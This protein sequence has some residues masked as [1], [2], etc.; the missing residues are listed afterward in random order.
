MGLIADAS[1]ACTHPS[2][3]F[4]KQRSFVDIVRKNGGAH[5]VAFESKRQASRR[6]IR[7]TVSSA[8][9]PSL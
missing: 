3:Q 5:Q 8:I 1:G 9:R 2:L 7:R 6:K 4:R